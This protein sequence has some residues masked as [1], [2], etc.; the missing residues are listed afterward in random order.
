MATWNSTNL[1]Y[2]LLYCLKWKCP[3]VDTHQDDGW[4]DSILFLDHRR[5]ELPICG[6]YIYMLRMTTWM[7]KCPA[8]DSSNLNNKPLLQ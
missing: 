6:K 5:I 3:H 1:H 2:F 7:I 8:T 4:T